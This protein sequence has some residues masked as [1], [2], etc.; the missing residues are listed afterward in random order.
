[1]AEK[2]AKEA[3]PEKEASVLPKPVDPDK[4]ARQKLKEERK[5]LRQELKEQRKAAKARELELAERTAEL[6]GE[7]A[8][9][10]ATLILTVVIILVWLAIMGML[11][12]LD[13]GGF[14]SNVLAPIIGDVP[15]LQAILPEGSYTPIAQKKYE[16]SQKPVVN[17]V[18]EQ[19]A[20]SLD[21]ANLYIKRLEEELRKEMEENATLQE[22]NE[23]LQTEI[24]R[25]QPFEENQ[26][27]LEQE[28]EDFYKNIVYADNAPTP[29]EYQKYYELI[30]PDVAAQIYAQIIQGTADDDELEQYVKAYSSMK[31]KEAAAIFN[32][33]IENDT[34]D[35]V[36]LIS[37]ILGKMSAENRG[38]ILDKMTEEYAGKVT[39]YMEPATHKATV[40][41][42]GSSN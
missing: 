22:E 39:D 36:R 26:A 1:M 31:A 29:E 23:K 19:L 18:D 28:K 27:K 17:P 16:E 12:K 21:E 7:D 37:K 24:T 9:G 2:E 4:E 25:L 34:G 20:S 32:A 13:V 41:G 10:V 14:G 35:A 42:V 30:E 3:K 40:S 8:G 11:I 5:A 15:G 38:A 33:M 6:N